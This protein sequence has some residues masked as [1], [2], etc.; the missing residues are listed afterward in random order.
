MF[1]ARHK[2][3]SHPLMFTSLPKPSGH[4]ADGHTGTDSGREKSMTLF[5]LHDNLM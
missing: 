2:L 1:K 3:P 4:V 5:Y